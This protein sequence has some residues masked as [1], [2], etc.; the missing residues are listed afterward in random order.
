MFATYHHRLV[1]LR[2]EIYRH[3]YLPTT[4]P[5]DGLPWFKS[6]FA[7]LSQWHKDLELEKY[8]AG[9]STITCTVGYHATIIFLFQPLMLRALSIRKFPSSREDFEGVPS[10]SYYSACK[11]IKTYEEV[12]QAPGSSSL[13]A[14]PM[15]F[16]S[17]HYIYLAALTLMAHCQL[18]LTGSVPTLPPWSGTNAEGAFEA[19]DFDGIFESCGSCLVLLTW[20]AEKWRGMSGMLDTYRRLSETLLPLI[21]RKLYQQVP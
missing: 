8:A 14:Y 13:G 9:V 1:Y 7:T 3:M 19:V 17:A 6:Q 16:M 4:P 5:P 12:L 2:S 10:D 11:L 20:C 21:M 15:T 18:W